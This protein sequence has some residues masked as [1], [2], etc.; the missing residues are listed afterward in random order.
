M[1][2]QRFEPAVYSRMMTGSHPFVLRRESIFDRSRVHD[3][4]NCPGDRPL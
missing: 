2:A 1:V 4:Q 3:A